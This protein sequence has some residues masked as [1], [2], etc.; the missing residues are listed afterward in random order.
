MILV[1]QQTTWP[2]I[3]PVEILI[4]SCHLSADS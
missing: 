3:L 4:E 2:L 1:L